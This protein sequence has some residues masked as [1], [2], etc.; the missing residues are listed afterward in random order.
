MYYGP[1]DK[2]VEP[3]PGCKKSAICLK[4]GDWADC[5]LDMKFL[6]SLVILD[7]SVIIK[8]KY[9]VLWVQY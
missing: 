5:V 3:E 1:K 2:N 8:K 7:Y 9:Y 4:Q 6:E